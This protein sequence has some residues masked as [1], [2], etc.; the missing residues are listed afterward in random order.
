[1]LRAIIFDFNGVII[2]DEPLHYLA[3]REV[4]RREKIRL[5]R[6][7]YYERYLAFDDRTCIAELL[8]Q[9]MKWVPPAHVRR[10]RIAKAEVY[11]RLLRTRLKLFPGAT[12]L[13][14]ECSARY[15]LAIASGALRSEIEFILKKFKLGRYF[16]AVVSADDVRRGKPHP[17]TFLR[18]Y[19]VLK[20]RA[21]AQNVHLRKDECLV[22]EDSLHG[23][24]AAH[25]AGMKCA[26]LAHSYP[27]RKLVRA[28]WRVRRIGEMTLSDLEALYKCPRG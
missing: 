18:A 5:T 9:R 11:D 16:S 24:E 10:L 1:M 25:E 4:F 13:I 14:R 8:S 7:L 3:F 17:E 28:D 27:F 6:S 20:K 2:D 19:R 22:I 23:I 15:P 26:A 21:V 12:N